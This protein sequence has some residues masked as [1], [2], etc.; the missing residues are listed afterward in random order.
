MPNVEYIKNKNLK[1]R[2][3]DRKNVEISILMNS[4]LKVRH[5]LTFPLFA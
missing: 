3:D 2:K 5:W 4:V 1:I